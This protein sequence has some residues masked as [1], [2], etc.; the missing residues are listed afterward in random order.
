MRKLVWL[1][2]LVFIVGLTL[3]L[4][5][6]IDPKFTISQTKDLKRNC[7]YNGT[8]CD[9]S[10]VCNITV[11]Y[12]NQSVLINNAKMT[13][14]TSFF[15]YTLP[16]LDNCETDC[17]V[18]PTSVTCTF[19]GIAGTE[20][21]STTITP[22]GDIRDFSFALLLI[23]GSLVFLL[24]GLIFKSEVMGLISGILFFVSGVYVLIYGINNLN[25]PYTQSIG[26]ICIGLG[27]IFFLF[28]AFEFAAGAM[29][30]GSEAEESDD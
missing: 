5:S 18:Y 28:S 27:I 20:T 15:N 1:F 3:Q 9:S 12:P 23:L 26:I 24:L 21:F 19:A 16:R 4:V 14:Q 29:G 25:D 22:T 10:T 13:Y 17:G 6:A 11:L 2:A 30:G 7:Q 8:W